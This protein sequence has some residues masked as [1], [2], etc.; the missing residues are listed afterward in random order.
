MP[1][2]ELGDIVVGAA[3]VDLTGLHTG[4][5]GREHRA[6]LHG[7]H[8][9]RGIDHCIGSRAGGVGCGCAGIGGRNGLGTHARTGQEHKGRKADPQKCFELHQ[10]FSKK[11]WGNRQPTP[12]PGRC[13]RT[14]GFGVRKWVA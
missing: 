8:A 5:R 1:A 3:P 12:G 11:K 4:G 10:T 7:R 2:R 6:V 14:S 9:G 13:R